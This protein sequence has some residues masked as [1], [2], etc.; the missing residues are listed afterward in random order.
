M[1]KCVDMVRCNC[2]QRKN[3]QSWNCKWCFKYID[4]F[5]WL[6]WEPKLETHFLNKL[7]S[8]PDDIFLDGDYSTLGIDSDFEKPNKTIRGL[9]LDAAK[10]SNLKGKRITIENLIIPMPQFNN[11]M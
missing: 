5:T 6:F 1:K 4:I 8:I 2:A 11:W 10:L 3:Q 9:E 7:E